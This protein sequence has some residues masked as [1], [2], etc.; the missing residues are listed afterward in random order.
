MK[1]L[2]RTDM[3]DPEQPPMAPIE[4]PPKTSVS[5]AGAS[6]WTAIVLIVVTG[7][8]LLFRSCLAFP[9][10]AMQKTA[11]TL[12]KAREALATVAGAFSQRTITTSF[13]SYAT[14]ITN[15]QHLQFA[16]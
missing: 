4:P 13:V 7:G 12:D 5:W 10:R 1:G 9:E 6:M 8:V 14:T 3:D 11:E 16:T 2:Q 15:N